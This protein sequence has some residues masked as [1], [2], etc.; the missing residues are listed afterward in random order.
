MH[1]SNYKSNNMRKCQ[2]VQYYHTNQHLKQYC[3]KKTYITKF[4]Y[5][6]A[7]SLTGIAYTIKKLVAAPRMKQLPEISTATNKERYV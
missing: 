1:K 2:F 3:Q 4:F 6:Q 7:M 5:Y